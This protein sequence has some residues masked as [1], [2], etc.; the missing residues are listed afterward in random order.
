MR[1]LIVI[2][3]GLLLSGVFVYGA[4]FINKSRV[5]GFYA[6]LAVWLIFCAIDYYIGVFRAGYSALEE[7]G[8]HLVVFAVPFA[9]AWYLSR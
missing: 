6:F 9:A 8:V 3:I 2:L 4:N 5:N 7:L 1:T